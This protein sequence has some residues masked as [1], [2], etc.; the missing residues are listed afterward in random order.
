MCFALNE[1]TRIYIKKGGNP[2][3]LRYFGKQVDK[4]NFKKNVKSLH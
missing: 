3:I 1:I 4:H 2:E